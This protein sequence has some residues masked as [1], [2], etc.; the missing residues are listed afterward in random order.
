MIISRTPLRISFFGG[1][2]DL[3]SYYEH[4]NG[5]VISTGI[6]YF[7]YV[8]L[9]QQASFV[10]FPYR[11][12]WSQVEFRKTIDEIQHPIVREAFKMFDIDSPL[13]VTTFSDIP[14]GTGLGSSSSFAVGLLNALHGLRGDSVSRNT[15]VD[16]AAHIEIDLL[17]RTMGR[18]DHLAAAY[19]NLNVYTFMSGDA[20]TVDPVPAQAARLQMLEER[21]ILFYT[22]TQRN[23][24]E[25]LEAQNSP[26]SEQFETL[27][28]MQDL[29]SVMTRVLA[30]TG[31]L[32]QIGTML[33]ES[34]ML[35]RSVSPAI[36]N[37]TIDRYYDL[38]IQAGATG[39]KILGAGGGGF[40]MLYVEPELRETVSKALEPLSSIRPMFATSGS[41]IT[42]SESSNVE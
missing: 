10:E 11:I 35:K 33:H 31:E 3:R 24:S 12:N 14:A 8:I 1:G 17:G 4:Q 27:G 38:A 13:E 19:G 26:T 2:T 41:E 30:G 6:Q 21:L 42:Y 22:G 15:L 18:Q 32:S 25:I 23:A 20:V 29:V 40:L 7:L 39:G 34:W 16:E 37:E 28:R 36:S 9:R 5:Q